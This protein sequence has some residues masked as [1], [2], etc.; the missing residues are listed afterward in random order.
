[1][2][3]YKETK[4]VHIFFC[5]FCKFEEENKYKETKFVHIFLLILQIWERKQTLEIQDYQLTWKK[6]QKI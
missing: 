5:L 3:K 1:M 6:M 2:T 4:F